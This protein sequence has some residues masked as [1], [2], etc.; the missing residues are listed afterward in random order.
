VAIG[1]FGTIFTVLS[2]DV[3]GRAGIRSM[4]YALT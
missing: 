2:V 3:K 1:K 4:N